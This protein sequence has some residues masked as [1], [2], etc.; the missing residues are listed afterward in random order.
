M[1]IKPLLQILLEQQDIVEGTIRLDHIVLNMIDT[2][3]IRDTDDIV[4]NIGVH[5]SKELVS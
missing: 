3:G 2:A 4:E 5:K 1:K